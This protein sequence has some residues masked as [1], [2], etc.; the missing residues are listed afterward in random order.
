M[1]ASW[2]PSRATPTM[3]TTTR[4]ITP[5]MKSTRSS[6]PFPFFAPISTERNSRGTRAPPSGW[7]TLLNETLR[8]PLNSE[9]AR[10]RHVAEQRGRSD[11]RGACEI[12]EATNAHTVGPVS[13]E[14]GDRAFALPERVGPLT[15]AGSAPRLADLRA[16]SAEDVGDRLAAEPRI[17]LLDIALDPARAG[18]HDEL[19]GRARRPLGARRSKD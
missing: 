2:L 13:I 5:P 3:K 11:D 6:P 1:F 8:A 16:R 10:R 15:E 7:K 4:N 12:A 17:G 18:K 9:L 19:L 14:R